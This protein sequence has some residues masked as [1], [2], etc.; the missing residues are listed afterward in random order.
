MLYCNTPADDTR[1][2]TDDRDVVP[3]DGS[4][5]D[6]EYVSRQSCR[7]SGNADIRSS[8]CLIPDRML[9]F[10]L[11]AQMRWTIAGLGSDT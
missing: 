3:A 5:G 10:E 2:T 11:I 1:L 7:Y 9:H 4:H 6:R 8:K